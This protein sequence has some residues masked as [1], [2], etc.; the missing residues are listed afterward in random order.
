MSTENPEFRWPSQSAFVLVTAGATLSL[1]DFLA[2]P[3]LAIDNGGGAFL[4]LYLIFLF[5]LGMPLLMGEIMLGRMMKTD[6]V[7]GFRQLTQRFGNSVYWELLGVLVLLAAFLVVVTTCVIGGWSLSYT[8]KSVAGVYGGLDA[9]QIDAHLLDFSQDGERL[10]LWLTLFTIIVVM[11][12]AQRRRLVLQKLLPAMVVLMTA[13]LMLCL[14]FALN[15]AQISSSVDAFLHADM[16][17]FSAETAVLALQRAFYT[18]ALALG[19]GFAFGSYF[20]EGLPIGY[21]VGLIVTVDLLFTIGSALATG[22]F[23]FAAGLDFEMGDLFAFQ[24]LPLAFNSVAG[25]ES[26]LSL[27]YLMFT[28]AALTTAVALL[29]NPARYLM[30]RYGLSRNSAFSTLGFALWVVGMLV[31][32]SFSQWRGEGFSLEIVF[33]D[34]LFRVI[35][36]AGFQDVIVFLSSHFIQPLAALLLCFYV[37]WI[38]PRAVS[39]EALHLRSK[40][41]FEIWSYLMRYITPALLLVIILASFRLI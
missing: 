1:N 33:G 20:D 25:G 26:L 2:F 19:L 23:V 37:A 36:N 24:I 38:L 8:L 27:I 12:G 40:F 7:A 22:A 13:L 39:Y 16:T 34:G 4:L 32:L 14:V 3:A 10:S 28:L 41:C 21:S 18:L 31:I 30:R 6:P 17:H 5:A 35:D 15:F 9:G 29:E 11:I